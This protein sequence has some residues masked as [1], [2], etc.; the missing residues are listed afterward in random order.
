MC[1]VESILNNRPLTVASDDSR[2]L[3]PLTPYHLLLLKSDAPM[4]PGTFQ[5]ED[6]FSRRR[7]R[8]VQYLADVFRKKV[9][10]R[11]SPAAAN[12]PKMAIPSQK[13]CG[14]RYCVSCHRK[15]QSG[16]MAT[17]KN[18]R[19]FSEQKGIRAQG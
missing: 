13:S 8:Q 12:S 5:R 11:I 17:W 15:H 3:E 7:W 1:E 14:W 4:P 9:V 18:P 16:S 10:T 19:N 2:D 6:L